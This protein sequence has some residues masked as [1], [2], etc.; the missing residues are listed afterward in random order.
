[1]KHNIYKLVKK[2]NTLMITRNNNIIIKFVIVL[3]LII[4]VELINFIMTL[5]V[6]VNDTIGH[7]VVDMIA[8]IKFA[9]ILTLFIPL[10]RWTQNK[11]TDLLKE[12][13]VVH[14]KYVFLISL[15]YFIII[16]L[17]KYSVILDVMDILRNKMI[18]GNPALLLNYSVYSYNTLKYV[19]GVYQSFSSELVLMTELL[20][21]SWNLRN[22]MT[23]KT[24]EE[25]NVKYDSFLYNVNLKYYSLALMITSFLSINLFKYTFDSMLGAIIF[26]V[27]FFLF[28]IQIPLHYFVNR[29]SNSSRNK[30]TK[31]NFIVFHRLTFILGIITIIGFIINIGL[32]LYQH[33]LGIGTYRIFTSLISLCIAIYI[34]YK[35]SKTK[36]LLN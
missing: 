6:N 24:I 9:A 27:S 19:M 23:L 36:S 31:S 22:I 1:M 3:S 15:F 4:L 34:T 12:Q 16:Y 5:Y 35:I 28:T 7:N 30:S 14:T 18:E 10:F 29:I 20:F 13:I 8:I 33:E 26:L 32:N 2:G 17:F 25:E 11:N 21:I